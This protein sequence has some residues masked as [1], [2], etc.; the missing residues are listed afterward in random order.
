VAGPVASETVR[1]EDDHGTYMVPVR[2]NGQMTIPFVID[3]GAADTAIPADVF[4]ALLRTQ[5]VKDSDFIGTGSYVMADGSEH[6]SNRF[7]LRELQVGDHI[8]RNVIA[9]VVP[10]KG[11]PLLGQTF[12]SKL[13]SWTIDNVKHLLVL[14]DAPIGGGLTGSGR[15]IG[16]KQGVA[17]FGRC[18]YQLVAGFFPCSEMVA[19]TVL[20]N[21][22][23]LLSFWNDEALFT[24]SGGKDRQPNLEN[25]YLSIDT[26]SMKPKDKPE[27]TDH[28]MEGEC[29]FRSNRDATR[30]FDIKCD[31]YNR[32]KGSLYNFYLEKIRKFNRKE[33]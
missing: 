28:G 9:H 17:F 6:S 27:A 18:R 25:Y 32:A 29:Q 13:P 16:I 30:F 24:L 10:V 4:L 31:V 21:G 23:S 5:T 12:L 8:V 26:L 1:L 2:I 7:V 20:K 3:T 33:F 22:R 11:D 14:Q 19:Y 15:E